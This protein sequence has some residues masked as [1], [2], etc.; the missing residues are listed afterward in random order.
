MKGI[1]ISSKRSI[2][3]TQEGR[4]KQKCHM[5]NHKK[6]GYGC[7]FCDCWLCYNRM[8]LKEKMP[9]IQTIKEDMRIANDE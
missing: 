6:F 7:D 2:S 5:M 1:Y 8:I 9:A 3:I 4:M